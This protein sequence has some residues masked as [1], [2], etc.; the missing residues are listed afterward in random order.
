V[1]AIA[2]SEIP[3]AHHEFL[4]EQAARYFARPHASRPARSYRYGMA[5]LVAPDDEESPSDE[6]AIRKFERAAEEVGI[7]PTRVGRED[8]G[9]LAEFDALF[10][11]ETT[12]VDHHTYRFAR[13]AA[14]EGLVVIDDAESILRCTNKVYQAE[15]FARH[16]IPCPLTMVVH[17]ENTGKVA[18][19]IG[20]PCVLKQPDSSFSRGVVK[21]EAAAEL[22]R[23]LERL[24]RDSELVIAQRFEPS[25]FDWRIGVL[26][27][28]ALFACRYHMPRGE[29]RIA[30]TGPSGQRRYGRVEAVPVDE[31]PAPAVSLSEQAAALIG[32]GFYGVDVKERD[33]TFLVI[34]INDNPNVEAGYEDGVLKD[35][36]YRAVMNWF[37]ARLDAR[38][39]EEG[40]R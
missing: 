29:W 12:R 38:G 7:E 31:A 20:L 32:D 11:R 40:G 5:I 25:Q 17:D 6:A 9:R 13:R 39:G 1:R 8:Y 26:D 16:R 35:E 36:L 4:A 18:E 28:R 21:V 30:G 3:E 14:A 37:R 34:E 23:E 27:G 10:I 24:L 33:G 19:R 15:L 22:E 2:T